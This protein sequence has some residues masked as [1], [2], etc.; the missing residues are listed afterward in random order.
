VA[1]HTFLAHFQR[2]VALAPDRYIEQA[3]RDW[4]AISHLIESAAR[5]DWNK[6]PA[7]TAIGAKSEPPSWATRKARRVRPKPP[8][9][10]IK[11]SF[12]DWR[13]SFHYRAL[14]F[15]TLLTARRLLSRASMPQLP[16]VMLAIAQ[17]WL[18]GL[19]QIQPELNES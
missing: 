4:R 19:P 15:S 1:V 14:L 13:R 6:V 3:R 2:V 16:D 11:L 17:Q 9:D 5:V 8:P 18:E 7:L 10:F 12:E